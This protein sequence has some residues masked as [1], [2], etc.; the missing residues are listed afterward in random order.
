[1]KAR[2]V[3]VFD[4]DGNLEKVEVTLET[5]VHLFDAVWDPKDE[6]N[7]KNRTAFREWVKRIA[8]QHG[9]ELT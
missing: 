7:E 2:Q 4:Q 9:H 1:M 5:G 6:Q 3:E 8:L